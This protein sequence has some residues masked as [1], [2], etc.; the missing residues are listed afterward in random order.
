AVHTNH[1]GRA[2]RAAHVVRPDGTI[3]AY[4]FTVGEASF[5]PGVDD[6]GNHG[7]D[8]STVIP[9]PFTVNL[10][11]QS[12]TQV[13]VGSNGYMSFGVDDSGFG[14]TCPTGR[15]GT[16]FVLEPYWGDQCTGACFNTL[17]TGCGIFTTTTGSRG[18]Q[19]FY[20]E[21]RTNYY[22][23][24]GQ[25]QDLLNYEV[26]IYENGTPPF[27]FIYNNIEAALVAND[28]QLTV[29]QKQDD[30]CLTQYG[31]DVDGGLTPP[32]S[33]GLVLDAVPAG[34]TA[35]PTPTPSACGLLVGSG[36]TT[37]FEPNGWETI[38][39][40]NTVDYTFSNSSTAPNEFALFDTHDPWGFTIIKDAI[41]G[42][43]HTYTEFTPADLTGFDF[44]QYRVVIL[45]WDDTNAP[46]F[47]ADYP[48]AIPALEAYINAGGVVWITEAIQTCDSVP[49]PFGGT[50]TG[51][52]FGDSDP[53]VDP[54]SPM[55]VG[56]PNPIP[57]SA[58]NHLSFTGL[59]AAAHVVVHSNAD[60]NPALYDF[61][62][63]ETCGG[64]GPCELS[65]WNLVSNYPGGV[66][67]APCVGSDGTLVY[68]S[69][70]FLNQAGPTDLTYTYDPSTD[71]WTPK[72]NMVGPR[73]AT[74]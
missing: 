20:I 51:C 57:G 29:G 58:A 55:M 69:G 53:V 10:Y 40:P 13:A 34:A 70:G 67:E 64:P 17:C 61:R 45:N 9:L 68:A 59:P 11:G 35:T 28:S 19:I 48:A 43:G 21:Y 24:T 22:G 44:S 41:T 18:N 26:A 72:A 71:T 3:C 15:A 8:V 46:D 62:P 16:T 12:F 14:I 1:F 25:N 54:A 47:L 2:P 5:V 39:A 37:G 23:L 60:N 50:G 73:Y 42:A 36:M 27:E 74:R 66:V 33:T 63:N 31:C 30:V 56:M 65:T 52:E 49:M 38:L 6:T 32:V 7:D 4:D